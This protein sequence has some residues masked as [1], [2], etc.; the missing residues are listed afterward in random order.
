[1]KLFL[2]EG[3]TDDSGNDECNYR[4]DQEQATAVKTYL[5]HHGIASHRLSIGSKGKQERGKAQ[6]PSPCFIR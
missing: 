6:T 5:V 3:H 1:M 2:L 4:L